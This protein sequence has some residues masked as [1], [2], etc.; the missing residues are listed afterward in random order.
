MCN[1][2]T[3]YEHTSKQKITA[4][5]NIKTA[6]IFSFV[7]MKINIVIETEIAFCWVIFCQ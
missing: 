4:G 6:F 7:A 2:G 3:M 1:T 5:D